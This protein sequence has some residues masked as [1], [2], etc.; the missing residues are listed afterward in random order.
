VRRT[1]IGYHGT[2]LAAA[3]AI[4]IN[5]SQFLYSTSVGDWLGTGIYFFEN[6][7][8]KGREWAK[9]TV[10]RR[11]A[12][13]HE[14][15]VAVLACEIDLSHCLDLCNPSD[16]FGLRNWALSNVPDSER[17]LQHGPRVKT[18]RGRDVSVADLSYR[19]AANR[20]LYQHKYKINVL[21]KALIDS[22]VD[23][24]EQTTRCSTVRSAF[25][26]GQQ[27]FMNSYLFHNSQIQICV[28]DPAR[29]MGDL[30]I[31]TGRNH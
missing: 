9:R 28:R 7:Y 25:N 30:Q 4:L 26:S 29:A 23:R 14:E 2:T 15:H 5:P 18:H 12:Q 1:V 31:V 24:P 6:S 16:A 10:E 21:D 27:L 20:N 11:A 22:F 8:V 19:R 3:E 17:E 13:G